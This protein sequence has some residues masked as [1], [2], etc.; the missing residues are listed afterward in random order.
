MM[1][2]RPKFEIETP[3]PLL[4]SR[5]SVGWIRTQIPLKSD[6]KIGHWKPIIKSVTPTPGEKPQPPD[7]DFWDDLNDK[8]NY[9]GQF[10]KMQHPTHNF[11]SL[12]R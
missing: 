7:I 9:K 5:Q 4:T 10:A 6:R 11:K 3:K 1:S 2:S 12:M 8:T